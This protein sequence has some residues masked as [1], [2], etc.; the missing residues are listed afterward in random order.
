MRSRLGLFFTSKYPCVGGLVVWSKCPGLTQSNWI[1]GNSQKKR[2]A[3]G[4]K[5]G[6]GELSGE[7]CI[8]R[9]FTFFAYRPTP[10]FLSVNF[11]DFAFQAALLAYSV[12][13]GCDKRL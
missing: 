9:I 10:P 1:M 13:K 12:E 5:I 6:D 4:L 8:L 2:K 7:N 11:A 3:L